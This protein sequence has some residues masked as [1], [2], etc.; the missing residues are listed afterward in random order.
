M[1]LFSGWAGV[2]T[3]AQC[4]LQHTCPLPPSQRVMEMTVDQGRDPW[5][6]DQLL[7]L[8][9]GV[10]WSK[11]RW[12]WRTSSPAFKTRGWTWC[13]RVHFT[14]PWIL[15]CHHPPAENNH[16]FPL[17]FLSLLMKA[18]LDLCNKRSFW[19]IELHNHLCCCSSPMTHS[20]WVAPATPRRLH[21]QTLDVNLVTL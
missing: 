3:Q 2:G 14:S 18:K 4:F 6:W 19:L 20:P 8:I 16:L 12:P 17:L 10:I 7:L 15:T 11:S 5:T 21:L 9:R 1:Q 13:L